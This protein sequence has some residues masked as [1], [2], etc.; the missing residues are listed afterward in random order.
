MH[1][2][3]EIR[4]APESGAQA[5]VAAYSERLYKLAF[6]LC[7]NAVLAE[8]LAMRTLARAVRAEGDFPSEAAYFSFLCTI[9][10]NLYRD[11]LRLKG[12]NA[13]VFMEELPERADERPDPAASLIAKS[14]A[15][16]VR[17]AI[18]RLSPL[19]RETVVLR[20]FSNLSVAEIAEALVV[21]EGTVK[22]RLSEARRK[23]QQILTQRFGF[24]SRSTGGKENE[25]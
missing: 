16:A 10:V 18:A 17:K 14:D 13:L 3:E 15:E 11:D 7:S 5:L 6:R 4:S 21:P 23:I 25:R 12:A 22:F 19:L 1:I 9:L 2:W 20:Y 24:S 8:D